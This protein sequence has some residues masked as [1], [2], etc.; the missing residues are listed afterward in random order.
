MNHGKLVVLF[1]C[2][3]SAARS[4]MSEAL[5]RHRPGGRFDAYSAGLE[6]TVVHSLAERV[7]RELGVP[8]AGHRAKHVSEC[9]GRRGVDDAITLPD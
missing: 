1:L 2:T 8:L 3:H 4:Q 7:I 5:L 9:L 6:P